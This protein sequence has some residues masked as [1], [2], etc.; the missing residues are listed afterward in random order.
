MMTARKWLLALASAS[1]MACAAQTQISPPPSEA[2]PPTTPIVPAPEEPTSTPRQSP[3][4][5]TPHAANPI[6]VPVS[7]PP[8]AATTASPPAATESFAEWRSAFRVKAIAA[9]LSAAFVDSALAGVEPEPR[10]LELV[11]NQPEVV[12]PFWDYVDRVVNERRIADGRLRFADQK[13]VL[14]RTERS[15]GVDPRIVAAIWGVET[16]YGRIKGNFDVVRALATMSFVQKRRRAFFDANLIAA[17]QIIDDG[18]QTRDRLVGSWAG[19]MGHTQFMPEV[20]QRF[21]ADGDQDG[22]ADI[23]TNAADGLASAANYLRGH[24]WRNG[25]PAVIE[26]RL[27]AAFDYARANGG[28]IK[29]GDWRAIGLVPAAGGDFEGSALGLQARLLVPAG[30]EGPA[31]LLFEN[32]DV[33]RRYNNSEKYALSVALLGQAIGGAQ[34]L[35]Q[36]WPR[37]LRPLT[38]AEVQEIQERLLL[39][40]YDPGV[41]DG[42]MGPRTRSAVQSFQ[43]AIGATPDGQPTPAVLEELRART[44]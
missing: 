21:G 31:F 14:D 1:L 15:Y 38:R 41:P 36:E 20:Y 19:A 39:L 11:N 16:D 26:A 37:H 33:I 25:E 30:A 3:G 43:G 5:P 18:A 42:A 32:F 40:G 24:G 9:G 8:P 35:Y 17:L 12:A 7:A 27:P 10:V 34:A 44:R 29:L 13:A 23:W 28:A 4:N 6:Q 2:P 22:R